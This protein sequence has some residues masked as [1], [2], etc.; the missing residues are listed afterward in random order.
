MINFHD[1]EVMT[2]GLF[3]TLVEWEKGFLNAM[4]PLFTHQGIILGD[5]HITK[6][7]LQYESQVIQEGYRPYKE[8]V[9]KVL[10][11]FGHE[12]GFVPTYPEIEEVVLSI[13]EASPFPDVIESLQILKKQ[14][15]LAIIAN[16]D[17]ELLEDVLKKIDV[18][19]DWIFTADEAQS[20]KPSLKMFQYA[21]E[22]M[23]IPPSHIVH[24]GHSLAQDIVPAKA[25]KLATVWVNRPF[26]QKGTGGT[27]SVKVQ[28]DLEVPDLNTLISITS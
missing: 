18:E 4:R 11:K 19:F 3:G 16:L 13:K 23:E 24:V 15:K 6:M 7:F 10:Q 26:P 9:R 20:Y 28:P 5:Q 2:F 12:H 8:V 21:L 25:S 22:R 27:N 14:Y 17:N 1:F